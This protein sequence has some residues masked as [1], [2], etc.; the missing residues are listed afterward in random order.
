MKPR[1]GAAERRTTALD[2]P[3]RLREGRNRFSWAVRIQ[4]DE[5]GR[6]SA[7]DAIVF[8]THQPRRGSGDHIE[9]PGKVGRPRNM[10]DIRIEVRHP[11]KRAVT[12]RGERVQDIV[13]RD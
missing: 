3:K 13:G 12:V 5:V 2:A 11:D 6:S 10:A 4:T 8:Q 7:P 1:T 9:A